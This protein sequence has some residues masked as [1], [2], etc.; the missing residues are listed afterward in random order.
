MTQKTEGEL[1]L[2]ES[3]Q[4]LNK[5]IT[6]KFEEDT[7]AECV[8]LGRAMDKIREKDQCR[9]VQFL[10][11]VADFIARRANNLITLSKWVRGLTIKVSPPC[12]F[13]VGKK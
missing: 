10:D 13:I 12:S 1:R 4:R 2:K 8:R 5:E 11:L 3:A 7:R 9:T 6:E